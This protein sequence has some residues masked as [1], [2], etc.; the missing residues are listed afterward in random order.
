MVKVFLF[1]FFSICAWLIFSSAHAPQAV[2][3]LQHDFPDGIGTGQEGD[4][5]LKLTT[6]NISGPAR[7]RIEIPN[8]GIQFSAVDLQGAEYLQESGTHNIVWTSYP[9]QPEVNVVLHWKA[10]P[11]FTGKFNLKILFS[12]LENGTSRELK[13]AEKNL[14]IT[15]NSKGKSV[16]KPVVVEN[17]NKEIPKENTSTNTENTTSTN[18][19]TNTNTNTSSSQTNNNTVVTTDNTIT[20]QKKYDPIRKKEGTPIRD[21]STVM[22]TFFRVQVA[23]S[24]Y[25]VTVEYFSERYGFNEQLYVDKV[26]GWIKYTTGDFK[27]LEEALEKRKSFISFPFKRPFIVAFQ[28]GKRISIFDAAQWLKTHP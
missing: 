13:L 7:L 26:D 25:E 27:T 28:D 22:G 16:E 19:N 20:P 15:F 3:T 23:A 8:S 24:H 9:S 2:P 4:L 14:N 5:H 6:I 18:T 17:P 12:Y 1:S 10:H 11:F 21:A